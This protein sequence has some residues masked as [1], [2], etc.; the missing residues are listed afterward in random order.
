MSTDTE[1]GGDWCVNLVHHA[2]ESVRIPADEAAT[3]QEAEE[4]AHERAQASLCRRCASHLDLGDASGAL[5]ERDGVEI[6][7]TVEDDRLRRERAAVKAALMLFADGLVTRADANLMANLTRDMSL[8]P[9]DQSGQTYAP[10]ALSFVA[11]LARAEA[12]K[13]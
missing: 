9:A 3:A 12:E 4:L 8:V 7:D 13:L 5:V 10:A 11:H 1:R 6:M 2:S